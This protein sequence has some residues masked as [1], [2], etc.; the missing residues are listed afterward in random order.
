MV[1]RLVLT[2]ASTCTVIHGAFDALG[3]AVYM[4][5]GKVATRAVFDKW[6]LP[7]FAD[8]TRVLNM[9]WSHTGEQLGKVASRMNVT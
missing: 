7:D 1:Q 6:H 5:V 4:P 8:A 2:N 9:C 3:E